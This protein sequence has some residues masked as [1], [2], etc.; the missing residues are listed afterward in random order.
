MAIRTDEIIREIN[1]QSDTIICGKIPIRI[2]G[3]KERYNKGIFRK[4]N[5]PCI[6]ALLIPEQ[7]RINY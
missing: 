6:K 1:I 4:Y 5:K 7:D 2:H 3:Q